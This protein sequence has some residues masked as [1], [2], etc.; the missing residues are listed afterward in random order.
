MA[1]PDKPL[2][3]IQRF[4]VTWGGPEWV[5]AA[6]RLN[7]ATTWPCTIAATLFGAAGVTVSCWAALNFARWWT[8]RSLTAAAVSTAAEVD[9]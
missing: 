9:A 8:R 3:G 6:P 1:P 5:T 2:R 7:G 4:D